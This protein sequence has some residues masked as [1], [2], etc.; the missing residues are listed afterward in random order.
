MNKSKVLFIKFD[1]RRISTNSA[2]H[3]FLFIKFDERRQSVVHQIWGTKCSSNLTNGGCQLVQQIWWTKAKC[4][5]SNLMNAWYQLVRLVTDFC[6][7]NLTNA[8]YQLVRLVTDFCSSNLMN[9]GKVLFIKFEEQ[10]WWTMN[11]NCSPV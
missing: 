10:I 3:R 7:S 6:S 5:S 11:N 4:C 2:C 8:G 1:E 9:E